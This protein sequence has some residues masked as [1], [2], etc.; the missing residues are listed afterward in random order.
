[1]KCNENL[2]RHAN[3]KNYRKVNFSPHTN[4][5]LAQSVGKNTCMLFT[6]GSFSG[7]KVK[8]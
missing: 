4:E 8:K 7:A 3:T 6:K 5:R 1:M 2:E